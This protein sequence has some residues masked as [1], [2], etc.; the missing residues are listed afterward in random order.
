MGVSSLLSFFF[1]FLFSDFLGSGCRRSDV[2]GVAGATAAVG[3]AKV[4]ERIAKYC[5]ILSND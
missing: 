4:T 5:Q 3:V 2:I 1:F